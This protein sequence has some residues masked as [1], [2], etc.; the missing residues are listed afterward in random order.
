MS[1]N[2]LTAPSHLPISKNADVV[3]VKSALYKLRYLIKDLLLRT[4][5]SKNLL[6]RIGMCYNKS[7]NKHNQNR[8][9][10]EIKNKEISRR[11]LS[12]LKSIFFAEVFPA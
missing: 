5:G 1:S 12:K 6:T 11:T 9:I 7:R 4:F 10:K 3:A 2:H 8:S